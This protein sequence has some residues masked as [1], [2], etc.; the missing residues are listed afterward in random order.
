MQSQTTEQ[1]VVV[2]TTPSSLLLSQT[3]AFRAGL[4]IGVRAAD[5]VWRAAAQRHYQLVVVQMEAQRGI[6]ALIEQAR[7]DEVETQNV[8]A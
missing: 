2:T 7:S 1:G 8:P 3:D 5:A 6:A 4:E